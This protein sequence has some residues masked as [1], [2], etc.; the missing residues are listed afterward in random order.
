MITIN[1]KYN[2]G[3]TLWRMYNNKPAACIVENIEFKLTAYKKSLY[4]SVRNSSSV[5]LETYNKDE[6]DEIFYPTKEKCILSLFD[7]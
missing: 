3:D 2:I 1:N 5:L 6:L 7:K 4:Y